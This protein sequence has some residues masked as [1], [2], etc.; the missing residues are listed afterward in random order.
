MQWLDWHEATELAKYD[1][2]ASPTATMLTGWAINLGGLLA[3]VPAAKDLGYEI[4]RC[5]QKHVLWLDPKY[6]TESD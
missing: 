4:F 3:P 5:R 2:L 6:T 1:I